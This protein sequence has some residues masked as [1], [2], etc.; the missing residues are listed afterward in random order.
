M[1]LSFISQPH[2]TG[3]LLLELPESLVQFFDSQ[4]SSPTPSLI[5]RGDP[6]EEMVLCSP[7]DTYAVRKLQTSNTVMLS[8]LNFPRDDLRARE[9]NATAA[10]DNEDGERE[11]CGYCVEQS[12]YHCLEVEKCRPRLDKLRGFMMRSIYDGPDEEARALKRA[13][14]DGT[15]RG[16]QYELEGHHRHMS[17]KQLRDIIQ[18]SDEEIMDGLRDFGAVEISGCYRI[19]TPS[20][21]NGFARF[22]LACSDESDVNL[23]S[24]TEY[25]AETMSTT[26]DGPQDVFWHGVHAITL[27]DDN[28]T[29]RIS[30]DALCKWIGLEILSNAVVT[31]LNDFL[32]EWS[33][34]GFYFI[35]S[36]TAQQKQIRYFNK[37]FLPTDVKSRIQALFQVRRKWAGGEIMP[38]ISDL[39]GDVEQCN[40]LLMKHARMS[41]TP[42]GILNPMLLMQSWCFLIR[43][44]HFSVSSPRLKTHSS[45]AVRVSGQAQQ[46]LHLENANLKMYTPYSYLEG[47]YL[48]YQAVGSTLIGLAN[49]TLPMAVLHSSVTSRGGGSIP[50]LFDTTINALEAAESAP[51][52]QP[53]SAG[54]QLSTPTMGALT[55]VAVNP[56]ITSMTGALASEKLATAREN[57]DTLAALVAT[58]LFH[59]Q[60]SVGGDAVT[61]FLAG[62]ALRPSTSEV[63]RRLV[64]KALGVMKVAQFSVHLLHE[65]I[66]AEGIEFGAG[67]LINLTGLGISVAASWVW[68]WRRKPGNKPKA[69]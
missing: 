39:A 17:L 26:Y 28:G 56:A 21:V 8:S 44:W 63:E 38:F 25:Q 3:F 53:S 9:L 33:L 66:S 20:F 40:L 32:M 36:D 62:H 37:L 30:E 29:Y 55:N 11:N 61:S 10:D 34:N 6:D 15:G 58:T 65:S 46:G 50:K 64:H 27:R 19:L 48:G 49:V 22:F 7:H 59:I 31:S 14:K 24:F 45:R 69:V 16:G 2:T 18:A 52:P 4:F 13:K 12:I 60:F 57:L 5:I 42:N 67:M 47:A 54:P 43:S 23:Q 35:E 1:R 51:P 68:G 41:R